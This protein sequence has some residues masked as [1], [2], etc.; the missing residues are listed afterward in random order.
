MKYIVYT[1]NYLTLFKSLIYADKVWGNENT[2]RGCIMNL[3]E[4]NQTGRRQKVTGSVCSYDENEAFAIA[5]A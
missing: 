4:Y 1:Y 5:C 3:F 2:I